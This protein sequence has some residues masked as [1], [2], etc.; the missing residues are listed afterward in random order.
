[1]NALYEGQALI[2]GGDPAVAEVVINV[3]VV[4][5]AH[6]QVRVRGAQFE[7]TDL[8]SSNGTFVGGQ[9]VTRAMVDPHTPISLGSYQ[10]SIFAMI[11]PYY[12]MPGRQTQPAPHQPGPPNYQA[13]QPA[14]QHYQAPQAAPQGYPPPPG[15]QPGYQ[16]AGEKLR[17]LAPNWNAGGG[18]ASAPPEGHAPL[19]SIGKRFFGGFVDFCLGGLIFL[20]PIVNWFAVPILLVGTLM[21][22]FQN[23]ASIG[24]RAVVSS[25]H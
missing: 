17:G 15:Q 25:S 6:L 7:I 24:Q 8:T 23:N 22:W 4:S 14:P 9:R 5:G 13:P 10:T 16:A 1:V 11:S 18:Q 12:A 21:C 20:I 19:A 2:V 3:S